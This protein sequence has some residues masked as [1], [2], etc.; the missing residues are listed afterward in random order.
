LGNGS[1]LTQ[2][3]GFASKLLLADY[4]FAAGLP[5]KIPS[6]LWMNPFRRTLENF[7]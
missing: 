4:L 6:R 7:S 2:G 3:L 1:L 5:L